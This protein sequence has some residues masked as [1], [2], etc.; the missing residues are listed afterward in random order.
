MEKNHTISESLMKTYGFTKS[1][2]DQIEAKGIALK[3]IARECAILETGI[4][5]ILLDRPAK[6][7]DGI[8]KISDSE[9][10]EYSNFFDAKKEFI[11]LEKFVPAS[12][13]ATR[14]FKFLSEFLNN[15]DI[16]KDTINSYINRKKANNLSIFIVGLEKFPFYEIISDKLN[17]H[18]SDFNSW[19]RYKKIY[20]FIKFLMDS[21]QFNFA[22]KPKAVLPFHKYHSHLAT[23][24]EE[25]INE[26]IHYASSNNIS[27]IHF[28]VTEEHQ[29]QFEQIVNSIKNQF[30]INN[31]TKLNISYSYQNKSTNTIGFTLENKPFRNENGELMFRPGGH[32]A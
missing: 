9:F 16:E 24:I 28:T 6:V 8:Q 19:N 14:M 1:D 3:N 4:V 18:F 21:E 25:H 13:A 10:Q 23:P 27:N 20:F 22:N 11:I 12:G 17:N 31:T 15:F 2:F 26:S 30:E 32:G 29:L 7:N 5:K